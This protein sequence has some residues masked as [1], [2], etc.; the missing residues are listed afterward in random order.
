MQHIF[1]CEQLN[2]N[3]VDNRS[4]YKKIYNDNVSD[5]IKVFRKMEI[6]LEKRIDMRKPERPCDPDEIR[7]IPSFVVLD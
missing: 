1:E 6:T 4:Q 5:Q 2:K 3:S 7:C